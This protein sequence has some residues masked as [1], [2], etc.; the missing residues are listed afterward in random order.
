MGG[1]RGF[2]GNG[3]DPRVRKLK[4]LVFEGE[5]GHGWIYK[6]ERYFAVNGLTE[7]EKMTATRLCLE[8][9]ALA[10][11]QWRD[12][13]EPI[14]SWR[15]FKDCLLERFRA[16][17]GGDFY[18]QFFALTR[19]GIVADYRDKFEYL[20]SR[21]DHILES[22]MEGNFIKGLKP[23]I[24]TAVRLLELR[25]LGKAMELAQLVEDQKKFHLNFK[26]HLNSN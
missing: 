15:Q 4:M 1:Y 5:D 16:D 18:E 12:R 3:G 2:K 9:K 17:E 20:A 25:N 23:K 24:R 7:E 14:R 22:T 13:R 6:V 19:E 10:W 26:S 11:Y 21:L 8:G